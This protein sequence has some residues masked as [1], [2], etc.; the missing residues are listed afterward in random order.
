ML[1]LPEQACVRLGILHITER[2]IFLRRPVAGVGHFQH[3]R[4]ALIHSRLRLRQSHI[5]EG[6]LLNAHFLLPAVVRD[7]H[8]H[9]G[10]RVTESLFFNSR[11]AKRG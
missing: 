3:L 10:I 8:S 6:V 1:N 9:F 4:R 5:T 2:Q 11:V 7:A